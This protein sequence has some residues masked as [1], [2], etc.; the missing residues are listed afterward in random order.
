MA[1]SVTFQGKKYFMDELFNASATR[2]MTKHLG[3]FQ[4]NDKGT[5][6]YLS[7][8]AK[9][10]KEDLKNRFERDL[11]DEALNL[12]LRR[13]DAIDVR[14]A[15]KKAAALQA[16]VA[17]EGGAVQVIA[18]PLGSSLLRVSEES[19]F[20][21]DQREFREAEEEARAEEQAFFAEE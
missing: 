1:Q 17:T 15:A 12:K 4:V 9:R 10:K 6:F 8:R 18:R 5:A 14:K 16:R 2:A 20:E 21:R 13:E 7:P 3:V 19:E 11:Y